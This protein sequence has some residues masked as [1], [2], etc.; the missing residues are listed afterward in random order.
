MKTRKQIAEEAI[1][2]SFSESIEPWKIIKRDV[3]I[4]R[5][6]GCFKRLGKRADKGSLKSVSMRKLY[7]CISESYCEECENKFLLSI[8]K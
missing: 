7:T 1:I 2:K 4:Q 3:V 6:C 8:C 5:A